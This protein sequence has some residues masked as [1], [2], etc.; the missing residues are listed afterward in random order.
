MIQWAVNEP[1]VDK[2]GLAGTYD[3]DLKFAP[4]D[5][6]IDSPNYKFGSIF[7]AIEEQLGLK[8]VRQRVPVD[9]LVID[10]VE[11]VPTEN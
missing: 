6:P 1:V 2:T 5:A 4:E 10:H 11:R 9:Y 3:Y 8:L 7:S